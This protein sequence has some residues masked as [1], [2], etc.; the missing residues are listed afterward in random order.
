[1]KK[2]IAIVVSTPMTVEVFLR[3]QI[4]ALSNDYDVTVIANAS[5][6][7]ALGV[8][9]R[10][11]S[12][13]PVDIRRD[14][15]PLA[16]LAACWTL[17]KLFCKLRFDL[18]HSV[19]PKAGL[20][21]MCAS[22]AARVS[23]RI[24][25]FTGQVWVTRQGFMRWLLKAIDRL[26]ASSA[27]LVLVDSPSQREFLLAQDVASA[28]NSTVLGDGS[29][30]GVNLERFRQD[31]T[32][33]RETRA[34]MGVEERQVLI[35]FLGRIKKDKGVVDLAQ[36]FAKLK[37]KNPGVV[38]V[39]VGPDEDGLQVEIE[40]ILFGGDQSL[41]MVPYT[42]HPEQMLAAADIFCLPSYREG[43][44]SVVIEA[45]ACGVPAVGSRIYGIT[46]SIVDGETGL[47]FPVGDVAGLE[48]ALEQLTGD[49]ALRTKMGQAA[50]ERAKTVFPQSRITGE[51]LALYNR[52]LSPTSV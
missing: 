52:L 25:V 42:H 50:L 37:K 7:D 30:S 46:D 44:G 45:G 13:I 27:T 33:R 35:L 9:A 34:S 31:M 39:L 41:H 19:T 10:L 38:L 16:D 18:V 8:L 5:G 4:I 24:H 43:F 32:V 48:A 3:D 1:M 51:L 20:L 28:E 47:L 49:D 12:F 2:R 36:A 11:V 29:I 14:I 26:I 17:Y 22:R 40:E 23:N 6:P 15:S 21:A